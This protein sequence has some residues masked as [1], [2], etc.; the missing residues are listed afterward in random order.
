MESKTNRIRIIERTT[1][2][3]VSAAT[4]LLLL[5]LAFNLVSCSGLTSIRKQA[6][7]NNN[8]QVEKT[9][10]GAEANSYGLTE[11]SGRDGSAGSVRSLFSG[12]LLNDVLA[13][14][15]P[16]AGAYRYPEAL[17]DSVDVLVRAMSPEQKAGQMLFSFPPPPGFAARYWV[18][19]VVVNQRHHIKS[20]ERITG[21]ARAYEDSMKIPPFIAC[22]QEGGKINRLKY[23]PGFESTPSALELGALPA[24]SVYTYAR[25]LAGSM[26]SLGINMNLA[27]CLDISSDPDA[28]QRRMLRVFAGAPDSVAASGAAFACGCGDGGVFTV[29]KHFPGYGEERW[30]SDVSL[31]EYDVSMPRFVE[32]LLVFLEA[33][34]CVDGLMM[35]S[36]IYPGFSD[37]PACLS[38]VLVSLAHRIIPD[39]LVITDDLW[40]PALR[41]YVRA[42][43]EAVF[44]KEDFARIT[45]LAFV[46]GNDMLL[47]LDD[48]RI[49]E[50]VETLVL[51]A[52]EQSALAKRM[53]R[54]VAKIILLK[55]RM[56]PGLLA[57]LHKNFG[58]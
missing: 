42:D 51:L 12:Q 11:P 38:P 1:V 44:R 30:N 43:Y 35:S 17:R 45:E 15:I 25:N 7:I 48:R 3:K 31:L 39:G 33:S 6:G 53:E 37:S 55:S 19:G 2:K 20:P 29:A 21:I 41:E 8:G 32:D 56:F 14:R 5:Y 46:A 22:D 27:P 13:G 28:L 58:I 24:D 10:R 26:R 23:I 52:E 16:A 54:S 9:A 49:P 4:A 18:G 57:E 47:I 40:A 50:M 34:P 36:L